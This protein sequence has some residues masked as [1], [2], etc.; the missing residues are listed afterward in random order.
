M[1]PIPTDS[2]KAMKPSFAGNKVAVVPARTANTLAAGPPLRIGWS[3]YPIRVRTQ[4]D[5]AAAA[6]VSDI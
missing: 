1:I 5:R 3:S 6:L 4:V 2:I